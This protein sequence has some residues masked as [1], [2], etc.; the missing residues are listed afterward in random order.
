MAYEVNG[1]PRAAERCYEQAARLAPAEAR[2]PYFL[3]GLRAARGDL[4]SGLES[5]EAVRRIAPDY[6][7]AYLWAGEWLLADG[8]WD[9]AAGA[10]EAA[11]RL[12]PA[13]PWARHGLARAKLHAGDATAALAILEP[14]AAAADV[15]PLVA[16]TLGTAYRAV[17]DESRARAALSR[18][19]VGSRRPWPDPWADAKREYLVGFG[20]RLLEADRL[21]AA[22]RSAEALE[23][24]E[25]LHAARPDEP[26]VAVNLAVLLRGAGRAD[27]ARRLLESAVESHPRHVA[28]RLNLAA[29]YERAAEPERALEQLDA[30]L[31]VDPAQQDALVRRGMILA[32]MGRGEDALAALD[33]ATHGDAGDPGSWLLAGIQAAELGR[34][35]EARSR[36]ERV[37]EL[38]PGR[39]EAWLVLGP[40]RARLSDADGAAAALERAARIRPDDARLAA[41]RKRVTAI[42][43]GSR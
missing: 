8:R 35:A 14:L 12:A 30:I 9:A 27:E 15:D 23:I 26:G 38:D 11:E 3:A 34:W 19:V 25:Q 4:A 33:G 42:L 16:R 2:W 1:F 18:G 17:G 28:L 37:V 29:S 5:L 21:L 6:V 31:A 7:P 39:F 40:V 24:L 20:A 32:R 41:M 22:G 10:F 36:L 43:E 13:D